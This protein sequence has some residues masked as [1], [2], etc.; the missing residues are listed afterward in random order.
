MTTATIEPLPTGKAIF[1]LNGVVHEFDN[2]QLAAAEADA[3]GIRYQLLP[4]PPLSPEVLTTAP[5]LRVL[6]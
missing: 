3:R 2:W 1:E 4:F 6:T 5:S